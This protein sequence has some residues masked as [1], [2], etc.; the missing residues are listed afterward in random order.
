MTLINSG[1]RAGETDAR[2]NA[3]GHA[4]AAYDDT[5]YYD[6]DS[7]R[8]EEDINGGNGVSGGSQNG[9]TYDKD[10]QLRQPLPTDSTTANLNR[11]CGRITNA[12]ASPP[13]H[14]ESHLLPRKSTVTKC[15]KVSHSAHRSFFSVSSVFLSV[16][17]H[18]R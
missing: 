15:R 2:Y 12:P 10:D 16:R 7:N 18:S 1:A 3:D 8:V 6:L 5:F 4:P 13:I 17:L 11:G 9:Y 14:P